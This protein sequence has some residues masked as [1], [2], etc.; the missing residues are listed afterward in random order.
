MKGLMR[1]HARQQQGKGKTTFRRPLTGPEHFSTRR[2]PLIV[3]SPCLGLNL[4]TLALLPLG[5][6]PTR[7]I[8]FL[9]GPR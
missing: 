5:E 8:F 1:G 3:I 4:S 9:D 6:F 2:C 7:V